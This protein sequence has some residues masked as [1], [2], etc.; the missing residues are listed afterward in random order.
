MKIKVFDN[1]KIMKGNV[2]PYS[3]GC[4]YKETANNGKGCAI[5]VH[6]VDYDVSCG[7]ARAM[8]L[9]DRLSKQDKRRVG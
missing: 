6:S 3:H 5:A 1:G 8:K 2:C 7:M 9:I 4:P